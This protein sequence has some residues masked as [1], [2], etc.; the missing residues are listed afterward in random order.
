MTPRNLAL[1]VFDQLASRNAF[2]DIFIT[3]AAWGIFH[4]NSHTNRRSGKPKI[5][6]ATKE[7]ARTAAGSMSR[8]NGTQ[9]DAYKCI[10]CDGY[11][12]GRNYN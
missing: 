9:F 3:H 2:R 7:K 6:H 1:G 8:S 4:E 12:I 10:F 5:A 11:H